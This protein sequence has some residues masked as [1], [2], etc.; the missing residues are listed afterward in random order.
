M[1]LAL[2]GDGGTEAKRSDPN[3]DPAELVRNTDET[4]GGAVSDMCI[5]QR[6]NKDF[7]ASRTF[8]ASSKVGPHQ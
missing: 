7:G 3:G 6:W 5:Y 1:R 8:A 4:I 2:A